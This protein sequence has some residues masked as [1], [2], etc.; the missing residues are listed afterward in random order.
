MRFKVDENLPIEVAQELRDGGFEADTVDEEGLA[1]APDQRIAELIQH[2]KRAFVTLDVDFG[3][4][5]RYP[6]SEYSGLI[7]LRLHSQSKRAVVR[8]IQ[9]ILSRLDQEALTGLLWTVDDATIRIH[10]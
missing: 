10:D 8:T 5:K 3:N 4:L 6:P 1:G 7:V 2:E 9:R